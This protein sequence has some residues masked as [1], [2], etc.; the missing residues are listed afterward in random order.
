MNRLFPRLLLA[1]L[2]V[3]LVALVAVPAAQLR[4]TRLAFQRQPEALRELLAA[5]TRPP[6]PLGALYDSPGPRPRRHD[7]RPPE[8]TGP[9]PSASEDG[10]LDES[11]SSASGISDPLPDEAALEAEPRLAGQLLSAFGAYRLAQQ[12]GLWSGLSFALLLSL[13]LGW[14][15]A[16]GVARPIEA[17]SGAAAR[18][19]AGD[20]G[21]RVTP[22]RGAPE[23][24]RL[25]AEDFNR[26][27][28]ALEH[29]EAERRAM[30][31][32]I[33][34]E[35]RAPLASLQFRLEALGDG[36]LEFGPG[37]AALLQR[38]VGL[39]A[40]LI[41]DL[42]TLSLADAGQL[43]LQRRETDLGALLR[44]VT[45]TYGRAA[46]AAGLELRVQAGA[47]PTLALDP[48]RIRQVLQNLLENALAM[49]PAGG[50]VALGLAS[51]PEEVV[52]SVEDS[53][54]GIPEERL[55]AIFERGVRRDTALRQENGRESSG[56]G[57]AIVRTLVLLHGGRVSAAN[58]GAGARFTVALPRAA[59]QTES[60]RSPDRGQT[61]APHP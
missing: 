23:E 44:D 55:E 21:A 20:L 7:A 40:R 1:L 61:D 41:G 22:V 32:D 12:N 26:M 11:P 9:L 59:T 5:R 14:L 13:G 47:A 52:L 16:R 33:A 45:A 54:P 38:Q 58:T 48:D 18:L 57:L 36:L 42:R 49:T 39:L 56:L 34:H 8:R 27:A 29:A 25:L 6:G 37:E 31:A 35:L 60:T 19:A 28:Q 50:W 24:A 3:A 51:G 46:Q 10:L 17:V 30:I 4:E 15:L 53:G 43:S 2:L